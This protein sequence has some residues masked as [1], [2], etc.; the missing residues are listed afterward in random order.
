M[1]TTQTAKPK[2]KKKKKN[3]VKFEYCFCCKDLMQV[4]KD[5]QCTACYSYIVM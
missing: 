2:K 1:N 5:G 3:S 4:T